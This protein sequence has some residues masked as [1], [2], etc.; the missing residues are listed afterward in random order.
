MKRSLTDSS[1]VLQSMQSGLEPIPEGH[2]DYVAPTCPQPVVRLPAKNGMFVYP[3][4]KP[5][6]RGGWSAKKSPPSVETD[7]K[8][9]SES[10]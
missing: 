8:D 10:S 5:D 1:K 9:Q 4:L 6:G 7:A 3:I 2:P